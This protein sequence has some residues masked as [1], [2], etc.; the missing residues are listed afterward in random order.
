MPKRS[1][2]RRSIGTSDPAYG[3]SQAYNFL[4]KRAR[5]NYKWQSGLNA[6]PDDVK[7]DY[8]AQWDRAKIYGRGAYT[9][10]RGK[11]GFKKFLKGAGRV[12]MDLAASGVLGPEASMAAGMVN[13]YQGTG[14]YYNSL[15][16]GQ[17][18][19]AV[20]NFNGDGDEIGTTMFSHSEYLGNIVSTTTFDNALFTL[21]PGLG[22][23]F[24]FLSQ[25]AANYEE[26]EFLQ[27]AFSFKSLLSD[28]TASGSIGSVIMVADY[29]AT[30]PLITT[31]F[32]MM[33]KTGVISAKPTEDIVCGIECDP[34]KNSGSAGRYIRT[35][36]ISD[37]EDLKSYDWGTFQIAT[38][39]MQNNVD[40]IGE[41]WVSYT[42]KLRKPRL[43][44]ALGKTI[45]SDS[46]KIASFNDTD[47]SWTGSSVAGV[48][49]KIKL[50][51]WPYYASPYN[52]I[53]CN[54]EMWKTAR[55]TTETDTPV[56]CL[57]VV[58]PD[59]V[60]SQSFL[61]EFSCTGII[62]FGASGIDGSNC[63]WSCKNCT[64][65]RGALATVCYTGDSDSYAGSAQAIYKA[66]DNTTSLT[67]AANLPIKDTDAYQFP[68]YPNSMNS[69][70]RGCIF[71]QVF[72]VDGTFGTETYVEIQI[73]LKSAA[74]QTAQ[75]QHPMFWIT[76]FNRLSESGVNMLPVDSQANYITKAI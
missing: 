11:F 18:N 39:G 68:V 56:V 71:R 34:D 1:Y 41:I 62:T 33:G 67:P 21:N 63:V 74:A 16:P 23:T 54:I 47:F 4:K 14:A 12:G 43:Y 53:G 3:V 65:D 30:R 19:G 42:V 22:Q 48:I 75:I 5:N 50:T 51:G 26:Y 24:P 10:G 29:N 37:D 9:T 2:R 55:T 72:N 17:T 27:L 69:D 76:Q 31:K 13:S 35:G 25:I 57:R 46:F 40:T 28:A 58:F 49:E 59:N 44:A 73:L 70:D 32:E 66:G 8:Q 38:D 45:A 20:P 6:L 61:V 15:F 60:L 7:P 36:A 52:N 64:P